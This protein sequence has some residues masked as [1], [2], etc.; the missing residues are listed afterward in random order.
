LDTMALK[1]AIAQA[2]GELARAGSLLAPLNPTMDHP[3][4]IETQVYQALLERQP[5]KMVSRLREMLT[6][7]DPT[8]GY[9]NGELLFWVGWIEDASGDHEAA[10]KSWQQARS[11]L[12]R[13]LADQPNNLM[14]TS[15]LALTDA[16]LGDKTAALQLATRA[17]TVLPI[18]KDAVSGPI[19]IEI[20]ARVSA[21]AGDT[22]RAVNALGQLLSLPYDGALGLSVPLTASLLRLDPM[23]DSLRKDPR[24]RDLATGSGTNRPGSN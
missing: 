3:N 16:F 9:I 19:S 1:A 21:Q 6:N 18:Q 20:I 13:F 12:E 11:E 15:D 2:Q 14:L 24:F 7:R 22:D 4:A 8:L 10:R 5:Q 17:A 23:F